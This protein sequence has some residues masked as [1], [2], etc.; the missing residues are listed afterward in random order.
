M[1]RRMLP[2]RAYNN[3]RYSEP[4]ILQEAD[5]SFRVA[6]V[7]DDGLWI[8]MLGMSQVCAWVTSF[9]LGVIDMQKHVLGSSA[10][11]HPEVD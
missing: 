5:R 4:I 11:A 9:F 1:F 10:R 6:V 2:K 7:T 3:M 8:L